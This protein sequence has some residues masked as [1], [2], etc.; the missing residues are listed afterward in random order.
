MTIWMAV[1]ALAAGTYLL[2]VSGLLL[3]DRLQLSPDVRRLFNYAA[4]ALLMALVVTAAIFD[5]NRLAGWER[6]A[7]VAA[8]GIAAWY[9]LPFVIVVVLAAG[10][11]AVLRA[12]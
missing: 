11:T 12:F 9:R 7:G 6:P 3:A 5:G 10:V 4:V 8:G 2:R 1:L